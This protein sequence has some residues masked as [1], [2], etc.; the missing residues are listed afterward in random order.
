MDA[1]GSD[2]EDGGERKTSAKEGAGTV[3]VHVLSWPCAQRTVTTCS[4]PCSRPSAAN[5]PPKVFAHN[6]HQPRTQHNRHRQHTWFA[7]V[8]LCFSATLGAARYLTYTC[9]GIVPLAVLTVMLATLAPLGS[10]T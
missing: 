3:I 6:T 8:V 2:D 10:E 5:W 7:Q 1:V 4:V 9:S